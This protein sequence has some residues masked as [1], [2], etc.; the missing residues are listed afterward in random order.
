MILA[1]PAL[2]FNFTS[3][4]TPENL[5]TLRSEQS[6]S[7]IPGLAEGKD[8]MRHKSPLSVVDDIDVKMKRARSGQRKQSW[9]GKLSSFTTAAGSPKS[10]LS[11]PAVEKPSVLSSPIQWTKSVPRSMSS[12]LPLWLGGVDTESASSEEMISE[13]SDSGTDDDDDR[14]STRPVKPDNRREQDKAL[15]ERVKTPVEELTLDHDRV[16]VKEGEVNATPIKKRRK[17]PIGTRLTMTSRTGYFQDRIISPSMVSLRN[18]VGVI[19]KQMRAMAI[20]YIGPK[21]APD[22]QT[23]YYISPILSPPHLLAHFPPVYFICGEKDPFV[24]DTVIFAGKLREAKRALQAEARRNSSSSKTARHGESLRMSSSA[25]PQAANDDRILRETDE[26]WVVRMRIIEG[27]GHGFMQMVALMREIDGVLN[28]MADWIDESF[29]KAAQRR[30]EDAARASVNANTQ[31]DSNSGNPAMLVPEIIVPPTT[32]Q[33]ARTYKPTPLDKLVG[34]ADLGTPVPPG[35]TD[36]GDG[37]LTFT[38]KKRRSPPSSLV[39]TLATTPNP[40]EAPLNRKDRGGQISR[41]SSAP[42]FDDYDF[43]GSP[44]APVR[45][46]PET[47]SGRSFGLFGS[48]RSGGPSLAKATLPPGTSAAGR[49]TSGGAATSAVPDRLGLVA[50][51]VAG[52]R[53]ASPALAN[54]VSEP[55]SHVT[56]AE[57]MRRRRVDAVY[58]MGVTDS[59][60]GSDA[61]D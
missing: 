17:A 38:P 18:A 30:H 41:N 31:L 36:E 32:V 61:E 20:L 26:D 47:K 57:M 23:D 11:S 9:G 22:F 12:K 48:G 4:M 46:S 6:E 33:P 14:G 8:H 27:W 37:I 49:R 24:D 13:P 21:R 10:T 1:Y 2:D 56:E 45:T 53:A 34:G 40:A 54:L 39:S 7:H 35:L 60:V 3:W 19:N 29:D 50:A 16:T 58:G 25:P 44:N 5:R 51:A 59:A 15:S 55:A 42:R 28:E 52:A 43:G